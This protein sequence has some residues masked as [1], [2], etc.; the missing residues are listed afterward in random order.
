MFTDLFSFVVLVCCFGFD[1]V[2]GLGVFV[3]VN[4]V[5]CCLLWYCFC[6]N[7][8]VVCACC[9]S[10]ALTTCFAVVLWCW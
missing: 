2:C 7:S 8:V 6:F 3:L 10:F 1:L 9:G 4:S 5:V